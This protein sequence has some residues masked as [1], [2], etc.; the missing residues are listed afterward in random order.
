MK[1]LKSKRAR[2]M[3]LSANVDLPKKHWKKPYS[4]RKIMKK[5]NFICH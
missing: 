2:N 5:V 3:G 4:K 1:Y